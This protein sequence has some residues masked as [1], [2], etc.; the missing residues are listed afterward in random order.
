METKPRQL[1]FYRP[2]QEKNGCAS[3]WELSFKKDEKYE[4]WLFF[5]TVAPQTGVDN[6]GNAA[7]DWKEKA[8]TVKMGEND[9]GEIMAVLDGRQDQAGFKGSLFH[10]TPA[11]GN[12][13][14][15][16]IRTDTGFSLKVSAQ[17]K[18]KQVTGPYFHAI[19]NGEAA[20][21][22]TLLRRAVEQIFGW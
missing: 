5:L 18:D 12:K 4:P 11:G 6:D 14:I 1:R 7:F 13:N 17:N 9:I 2:R 19:S 16:F 10:K 3:A 20:V 8:I 22:L 21:L 15:Q